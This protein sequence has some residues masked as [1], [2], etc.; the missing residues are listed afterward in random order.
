MAL[1]MFS[2]RQ[3]K[4]F[5]VRLKIFSRFLDWN[6]SVGQLTLFPNAN[7]SDWNFSVPHWNISVFPFF[8]VPHWNISVFPFFTIFSDWNISVW[9]WNFSVTFFKNPEFEPQSP[10]I[11]TF[12]SPKIDSNH[13]VYGF[14]KHVYCG[15]WF[16]KNLYNPIAR[17]TSDLK[18]LAKFSIDLR[19]QIIYTSI[20]LKFIFFLCKY[21]GGRLF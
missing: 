11:W 14:F 15:I 7:F 6:F 17:L 18:Q 10:M 9:H 5:S 4:K 12:K 8:I 19:F 16:L 13:L 2:F 20:E 3:L 21:R 1:K